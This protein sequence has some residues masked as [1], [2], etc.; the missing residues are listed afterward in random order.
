MQKVNKYTNQIRSKASENL[1]SGGLKQLLEK[2]GRLPPVTLNIAPLAG[3]S[4]SLDRFLDYKFSSSILKPVDSFSFA[5]VAPDDQRS[6]DEYVK[7]GDLVYLTANGVALCTGMIDQTD[8][9]TDREF[10]EKISVNGRD[11]M[12]QYEDNDAISIQDEPIWANNYTIKQVIAKL[13]ESTR[14]GNDIIVQDAPTKGYLFATEPSE[15]KLSALQRFLE[16]LNCIAWMRGDGKIVVGRPNMAQ[17]ARGRI[18]LSKSKRESNVLSLKVTRSCTQIANIIV[19]IWSGQE[20]APRS[21]QQRLLNAAPGPTRLRKLG[22]RVVKT[23]VIS[24]PQATDPQGYSEV[25]NF[26]AGDGN[27]L[28]AYAKREIARQNTQEV[29]VQAVVPGHFDENGNPW[30]IDTVYKIEYDRGNIDENM[31]LYE[32]EYTGSESDGQKTTLYFCRLGT[33]VSDVR[34]P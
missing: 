19:P 10:G 22:H 24:T 15:K 32:C 5:F 2:T 13:N 27:I 1:P 29:I 6:F 20:L 23:M 16:P 18:V 31:Y 34:A 17:P 21:A 26:K 9:E 28:K 33:I 11:C 14:I 3:G 25:N 7:E 4:F 8:I 30:Q 12:S